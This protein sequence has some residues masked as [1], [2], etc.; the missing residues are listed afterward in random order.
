MIFLFNW[1]TEEGDRNFL[2]ELNELP[3]NQKV[4]CFTEEGNNPL[5]WSHYGGNHTGVCLKFD[6][7]LDNDLAAAV[8]PIKYV[9]QLVEVKN[10]SDFDKCLLS[11]LDQ[12]K[13]EKEWRILDKRERFPFQ[14]E[15]LIEIVLGLNAPDSTMVWL[16]QLCE[17]PYCDTPIHKLKLRANRLVKL[18]NSDEIVDD[19]FIPHPKK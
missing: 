6:L 7:S 13:I 14:Q 10:S 5:M 17:F 9:E 19:N 1:H 16:R 2:N 11:K 8:K 4:T 18:N 15:A 3:G 12:W